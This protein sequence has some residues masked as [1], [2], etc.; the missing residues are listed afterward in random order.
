MDLQKCCFVQHICTNL[1]HMLSTHWAFNELTKQQ[2]SNKEYTFSKTSYNSEYF[3]HSIRKN[4]LY[5]FG[6]TSNQKLYS[7]HVQIIQKC[8]DFFFLY[9]LILST[10]TI[11]YLRPPSLSSRLQGIRAMANS[12][13]DSALYK[14]FVGKAAAKQMT[15]DIFW[16][17]HAVTKTEVFFKA[18]YAVQWTRPALNIRWVRDQESRRRERC[19][20]YLYLQVVNNMPLV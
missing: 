3:F 2:S 19:L 4:K 15:K 10:L 6:K 11:Y 14:T 18:T 13:T 9:K 12:F 17:L 1:W 5:S 7:F 20:F 16:W 8:D